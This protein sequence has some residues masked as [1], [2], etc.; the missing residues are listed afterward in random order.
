[1]FIACLSF[2]FKCCH[3]KVFACCYGTALLP[4]WLVLLGFGAATFVAIEVGDGIVDE[5]CVA[6]VDGVDCDFSLDG[7]GDGFTC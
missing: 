2:C 6:I 1:M 4:T 7:G 3:N 5:G